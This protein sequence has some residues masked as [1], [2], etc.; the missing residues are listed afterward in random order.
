LQDASQLLLTHH[1]DVVEAV[2]PDAGDQQLPGAERSPEHFFNPDAFYPGLEA[3]SVDLI[4]IPQQL[5]RSDM[6]KASTICC[7]GQKAVGETVRCGI[8]MPSFSNSPWIHGAP[9]S[10]LAWAMF[11]IKALTWGLTGGPL[12]QRQGLTGFEGRYRY[13]D[14]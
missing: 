2:S 5:R 9:H 3:F 6:G 1:E 8:A 10:G 13:T 11:R 4:S 7:V 12:F 14:E